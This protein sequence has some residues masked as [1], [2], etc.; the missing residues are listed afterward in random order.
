MR[1]LISEA[2]RRRS[3]LQSSKTCGKTY[4]YGHLDG[5]PVPAK[6][7]ALRAVARQTGVTAVCW[8]LMANLGQISHQERD[9][10]RQNWV[11]FRQRW[12]GAEKI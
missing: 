6:Q 7:V 3:V 12:K 8:I 11:G 9:E 10:P 4:T 2:E 1:K 5:G